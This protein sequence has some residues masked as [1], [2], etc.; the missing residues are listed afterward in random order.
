MYKYIWPVLT[1]FLS[2]EFLQEDVRDRKNDMAFRRHGESVEILPISDYAT[3]VMT[4]QKSVFDEKK[5]TG[6]IYKAEISFFTKSGERITVPAK[7][8]PP[9]L[10]QAS[11]S[12]ESIIIEYL[13]ESPTTIRYANAIPYR[14]ENRIVIYLFLFVG[15]YYLYRAWRSA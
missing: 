4:K 13:P 8:L 6:I 9:G 1:I 10:L 7:F 15:L 2:I 11:K 5:V 14:S 3:Y 12:G